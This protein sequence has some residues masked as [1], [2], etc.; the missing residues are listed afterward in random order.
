[1][2]LIRRPDQRHEA[3]SPPG[4]IP[5][6]RAGIFRGRLVVVVGGTPPGSGF[7]LYDSLGDLLVA[8]AGAA[9]TGPNGGTV[10]A[11]IYQ[12]N[13]AGTRAVQIFNGL[14]E[15]WNLAD[16][17]GIIP[18]VQAT[19]GN[20]AGS[21]LS[22]TSGQAA[23]ALQG[24]LV[25]ADSLNETPAVPTVTFNG[26]FS[27]NL[28][29]VVQAAAAGALLVVQD[30]ST[31]PTAPPVQFIATTAGD[32]V[33]GIEVAG[34]ANFRYR[35][36]SNGTEV[37]GP[38]NAAVD[39]QMGRGAAQQLTLTRLTSGMAGAIPACQV[40]HT[41][42]TVTAAANTRITKAWSIPA[43]DGLVDSIYKLTAW[44]FGTL[45]STLQNLTWG[46]GLSGTVIRSV[47]VA[48]PGAI[49]QSFRWY[50]TIIF[51]VLTT[52]AGGTGD[53]S[54]S[55]SWGSAQ[56]ATAEAAVTCGSPSAGAEAI[57]TNI[58]NDLELFVGWASITGAPTITCIGSKLERMGP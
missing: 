11:G 58:A 39:V 14:I 33:L 48:S 22:L 24:T 53:C 8:I 7:Y 30:Q 31:T 26:V 21:S 35:T 37:W 42:T 32:R 5:G 40:D 50:N 49:S 9:G 38:G 19:G 20:T 36:D 15:F 16:P 6:G 27:P 47:V 51:H 56:A 2:G 52:G 13:A 54:M 25:I 18:N 41:V 57:N 29:S 1:M 45:G 10:K 55:G 4:I 28:I 43:T 12:I 23:G 34:D 44:G 17:P 3:G 46:I